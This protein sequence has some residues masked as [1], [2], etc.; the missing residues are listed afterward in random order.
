MKRKL[1][2]VLKKLHLKEVLSVLFILVG[3]YFFRQER[4]ELRSIIP[5]LGRSN[6]YWI[7][8]GV[9][10]TVVYIFFQA[11]MY[12][13]SFA[14][15]EKKLSW[16][17]ALELFCKRNFL[18]VFLPAGGITALAY[19]PASLRSSGIHKREVHQSSG[20][21]GFIG[22]LS[23]FLVGLPV[24]F[25]TFTQSKN[26]KNSAGGVIGLAIVLSILVYII[27]SIRKKG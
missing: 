25:Y 19:M 2:T 27:Y 3:I 4:H 12:V 5:A 1:S 20:I 18:S 23:V 17:L 10:L 6:P 13:Y 8:T 24:I 22:I 11:G 9:L 21:Y 16:L 7:T 26:I 14:A 15:V